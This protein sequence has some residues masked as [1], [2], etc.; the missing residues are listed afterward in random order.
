MN[1]KI[2]IYQAVVKITEE[3]EQK[4]SYL[5][6]GHHLAQEI[7]EAV[8]EVIPSENNIPRPMEPRFKELADRLV[9]PGNPIQKFSASECHELYDYIHA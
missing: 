5:G 1:L 4:G 8:Y 3:R 9:A 2:A 7:A 6:N